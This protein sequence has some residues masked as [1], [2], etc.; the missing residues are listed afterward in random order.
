MLIS[1]VMLRG[2]VFTKVTA[3][4]G[5]VMHGF[6]LAHIVGGLFLPV[7]GVILL[8]IAGP[9]Y[10][11]WFFLVGLRLVRLAARSERDQL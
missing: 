11:F 3:W 9:L 7:S 10:P 6:D 5:I 2:A 8:V 4:L 1:A